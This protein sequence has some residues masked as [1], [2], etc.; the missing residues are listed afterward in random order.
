MESYRAGII[1]CGFIG[2]KAPDSHAQAYIDCD[3]T[4]LVALCEKKDIFNS[5]YRHYMDM[6]KREHLD[7]VSVCTPVETHCKIVCDIA[8]YVKAIY[9][10]KPMA[11]DLTECDKMIH[12]CAKNDTILQ[13]NHQRRF[14]KPLFRFS[15]DMIDTGTHVFDWLNQHHIDV[16]IEY[17]HKQEHIFELVITR[18]RM[19]LAGVNYLVD[20]LDTGLD[21]ISSGFEGKAAL[22][23][24][25]EFKENYERDN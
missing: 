6:V 14:V 24:A 11:V 20:C 16:D 17:V 4:A 13:I 19:I 21:T 25:L 2:A 7:I 15:R 3:R 5:E 9:C 18:E 23:L 12:A 10:E 22:R 1:G 8:P